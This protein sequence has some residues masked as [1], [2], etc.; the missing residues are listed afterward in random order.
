[1]QADIVTFR[2]FKGGYSNA[3]VRVCIHRVPDPTFMGSGK[4]HGR[5]IQSHYYYC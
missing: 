3:A 4:A 5:L 1:M 2:Q